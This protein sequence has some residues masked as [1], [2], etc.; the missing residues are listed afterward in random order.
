MIDQP[1][2]KALAGAGAAPQRLLWA[3]TGTKDPAY[4]DVLYVEELIG[5]DTVNTMPPKT[6]D[7]FRDHGRVRASLTEDVEGAAKV[8]T[9]AERLGLDLNGVTDA[10]VVDGVKKFSEAF[11]A[12]LGAV[13]D[14]RAR[15]LGGE[16]NG[17]GAL[18]AADLDAPVKAALD[19]AA[20]EGW[21]RRLWAK[22]ASLWTGKDENKWLGW[23]TAG[24]GGAVDFSALEGL[25]E[26]VKA[27]GHGHALLLGMG[28]SSLGPEVL[29]RTFGPAAG[30]PP[31][32]VLDSTDPDQIARVQ[33]QI[34]PAR[35]LFIVSSKSGS[36]LEPD[37]L[38]AH[39]FALAE[40]AM[41]A[42]KA[43]G[44]FIAV[45]DPGSKLEADARRDGFAHVFHGDP[46]IGGRYSVLSNFGMVPA[47]V[48]GMD[49][50]ALFEAA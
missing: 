32:L 14:K 6:M 15:I 17:Q 13:A 34:D 48:L 36:P 46:Q 11:D 27:A 41:G 20:A 45:T 43:A 19:H 25:R 2:G 31:L 37:I 23:L 28:G 47:A 40:K 33:A 18:L 38:R 1:R 24:G 44:H 22:D 12:L 4:S 5:P 8:L 50:R 30:H 16:L 21:T 10:L 35:T 3:S 9:D 29:A 42:G 26:E 49:V 39:F 7:G